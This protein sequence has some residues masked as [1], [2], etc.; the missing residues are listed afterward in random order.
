M[1]CLCSY[2]SNTCSSNATDQDSSI[3]MFIR[4]EQLLVWEE[5]KKERKA[6]LNSQITIKGKKKPPLAKL[7]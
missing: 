5:R 1:P 7:S 3:N 2:G 4:K 6:Q